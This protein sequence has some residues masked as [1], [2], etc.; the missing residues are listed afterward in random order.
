MPGSSVTVGDLV[1]SIRQNAVVARTEAQTHFKRL[2]EAGEA[3][4]AVL[5]IH[6]PGGGGKSTTLRLFEAMARKE[7]IATV[8]LDVRDVPTDATLAEEAYRGA[9]AQFGGLDE[10]AR[11]VLLIDTFES[12]ESLERIYRDRILPQT[13]SQIKVVLA[14]RQ[15]MGPDWGHDPA[16]SQ[17]LE[18]YK[19]PPLTGNEAHALLT[20]RSVPAHEQNQLVQLAQGHALTLACLASESPEERHGKTRDPQLLAEVTDRVPDDERLALAALCLG[21]WIAESELVRIVGKSTFLT[22]LRRHAFIECV[23]GRWRLHD[24]YRTAFLERFRAEMPAELSTLVRRTIAGAINRGRI[25]SDFHARHQIYFDIGFTLRALPPGDGLY[26]RFHADPYY[27]DA[28]KSDDVAPILATVERFEDA[29]SAEIAQAHLRRFPELCDVFRSPAGHPVGVVIWMDPEK[30][31]PEDLERDPAA[32]KLVALAPDGEGPRI[33]RWWFSLE[34]YQDTS[35]VFAHLTAFASS[36]GFASRGFP[37]H[38]HV[39]HTPSDPS[40]LLWHRLGFLDRIEE[41]EF[42]IEG[43]PYM[44]LGYDFR[45]EERHERMMRDV[46]GM[47]ALAAPL[48]DASAAANEDTSLVAIMPPPEGIDDN[49]VALVLEALR[50]FRHDERLSQSGL[51]AALGDLRSTE[52]AK[53]IRALLMEAHKRLRPT[54]STPEASELIT[55]A[56]FER[57]DKQLAIAFEMG[58]S[59]GT[60]RRRLRA[61]VGL[62]V[63]C[64]E[65]VWAET[66]PETPVSTLSE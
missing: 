47:I 9:L 41:L 59:L 12:H 11:G 39:V 25:E 13:P 5:A 10:S 28:L 36:A 24:L 29:K 46:D 15:V 6:A 32:T 54:G 31:T 60:F 49:L 48:I 50:C 51:G 2:L 8:W 40:G 62:L 21:H 16:W 1:S 38:A 63:V 4:P 26:D 18:T 37:L 34:G 20:A 64:V 27:R 53:Q 42:E 44:V 33:V 57:A 52:K 19:L 61:A 45:N 43:H 14:G 66:P 3:G 55:R 30:L 7:G 58:L 65:S 56:Y 23:G 35:A 17:L 22:R